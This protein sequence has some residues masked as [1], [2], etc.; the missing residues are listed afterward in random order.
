MA[1]V[2]V[3]SVSIGSSCGSGGFSV[4]E[5]AGGGGE[6][7]GEGDG[8][9]GNNGPSRNRA[10]RWWGSLHGEK[11]KS[12]YQS[13]FWEMYIYYTNTPATIGN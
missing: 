3:D 12:L 1:A 4:V 9:L 11:V 6:G 13:A 5:E 8:E 2:G 7:G 10:A